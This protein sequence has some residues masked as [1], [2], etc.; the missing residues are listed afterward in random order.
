MAEVP[1]IRLGEQVG[2]RESRVDPDWAMAY[3][4]A[5]NDPN[6]A[7]LERGVVPPFFTVSMIL[8]SYLEA[9]QLM[10]AHGAVTGATGGAHG[11][12]N[13]LLHKPI[14][15]GSVLSFVAEGYQASMTPA[16]GRSTVR[17]QIRDETGDLCV[18][19]FWTTIHIKGQ[20]DPVG[21]ELPEHNFPDEARA[22]KLGT[23]TIDVAGDQTYRYAGASFDH[24]IIHMDDIAA[25]R[26]G[27][28]RKFMQG[29]FTAACCS[30]AV[31]KFGS[32]G[33]PLPLKRMA[34][35]F[36]SPVYTREQLT[37]DTYDGGRTP[38]GRKLVHFEAFNRG[39]AAIRHGWAEFDL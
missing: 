5:T 13:L 7:Y 4:L 18:E 17:I 6:P 39:K 34:M 33:D 25:Q 22:N 32:N 36:S 21:P 30:Q 19:H 24:A 11:Q 26:N 28:E 31:I 27:M 1:K 35:R 23:L 12:H 3:A 8:P 38:E 29:L 9:N 37:I 14:T 2:P 20:L 15:P 16:G 10:G